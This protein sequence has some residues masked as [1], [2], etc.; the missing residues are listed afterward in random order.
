M[1]LSHLSEYVGHTYRLFEFI[2]R[3][4]MIRRSLD[5]NKV[6]ILGQFVRILI[7][8]ATH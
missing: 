3:S 8:T 7:S 2:G 1:K 6:P 5:M 4:E